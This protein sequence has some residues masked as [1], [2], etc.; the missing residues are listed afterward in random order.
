MATAKEDYYGL[1]IYSFRQNLSDIERS[2]Q[3]ETPAWHLVA[4]LV[5]LVQ[6]LQQDQ[7]FLEEYLKELAKRLPPQR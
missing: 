4:G 5:R 2:G 3:K 6:G 1:A 7:A